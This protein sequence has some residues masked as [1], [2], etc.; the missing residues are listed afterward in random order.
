[1]ILRSRT[2]GGKVDFQVKACVL[3]PSDPQTEW[4][5]LGEMISHACQKQSRITSVQWQVP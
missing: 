4:I 2:R 1:M 3:S 5:C